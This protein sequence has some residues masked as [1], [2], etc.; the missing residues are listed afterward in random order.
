MNLNQHLNLLG[1]KAKDRVTGFTGV[2]SSVTFDLYGCVQA[3]VNPGVGA[4]GKPGESHWFDVSR[5][6]V[7]DPAPVMSRPKYEW[8]PEVVSA[9]GK[10][11]G[12]RPS[13]NKV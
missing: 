12:E 5:L 11:A 7:L 9:G 6:E 1:L 4:D 13:S 10:G 8:T 3:I 2:I